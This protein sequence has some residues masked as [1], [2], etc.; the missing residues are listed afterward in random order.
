MV[1]Y[2]MVWYG[3]V[4]Y[5]P[6]F[7]RDPKMMRLSPL[8]GVWECALCTVKCLHCCALLPGTMVQCSVSV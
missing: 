4:W 5:G 3:M 2:G 7:D 1:W 6:G 8:Y